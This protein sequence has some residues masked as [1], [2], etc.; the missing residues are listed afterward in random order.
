MVV[1]RARLHLAEVR[2]GQERRKEWGRRCVC[3]T[4]IFHLYPLRSYLEILTILRS[5][6]PSASVG[7]ASSLWFAFPASPQEDLLE[8]QFSLFLV[9]AAQTKDLGLEEAVLRNRSQEEPWALHMEC[10]LGLNPRSPTYRRH[11]ANV[12]PRA[13]PS[14][15]WSP[16]SQKCQGHLSFRVARSGILRALLLVPFPWAQ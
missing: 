1:K 2:K 7:S 10:L 14:G 4:S 11:G 6:Q 15:P 16:E 9:T 8:P 3:E 12:Q 13:V 5:R